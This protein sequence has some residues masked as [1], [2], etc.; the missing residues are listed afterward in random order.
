[1]T[2]IL[3]VFALAYIVNK[4]NTVYYG[5]YS[6]LTVMEDRMPMHYA[7]AVKLRFCVLLWLCKFPK[8]TSDSDDTGIVNMFPKCTSEWDSNFLEKLGVRCRQCD[9]FEI[10]VNRW[11]LFNLFDEDY[12]E[13]E[14]CI[15]AC[16]LEANYDSLEDVSIRKAFSPEVQWRTRVRTQENDIL[17]EP[18]ISKW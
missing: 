4:V 17:R 14:S 15:K 12:L 5:N 6:Y 11:R 9:I 10:I 8:M 18:L 2:G 3:C 16:D 1:M 7:E 13:V